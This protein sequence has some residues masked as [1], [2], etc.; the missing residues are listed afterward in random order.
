MKWE[1]VQRDLDMR[2]SRLIRKDNE[3]ALVTP[4]KNY[5]SEKLSHEIAIYVTCFIAEISYA[6]NILR[7]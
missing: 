6:C 1:Q 2:I 5:Y 7:I 4:G 3:N